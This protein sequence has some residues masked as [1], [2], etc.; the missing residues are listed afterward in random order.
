MRATTLGT[1]NS[2][3]A[4][5][6]ALGHRRRQSQLVELMTSTD[7]VYGLVLVAGMIVVSRNFSTDPWQ[8]LTVVAAT[9]AVFFAAHVYAATVSQLVDLDRTDASLGRAFKQ[10]VIHSLGLLV[11][12]VVPVALLFIGAIGWL[13]FESAT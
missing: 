5:P 1:M 11:M 13:R 2:D 12:G 9:L 8:T 7:G 6:E 10:G 4:S 3:G